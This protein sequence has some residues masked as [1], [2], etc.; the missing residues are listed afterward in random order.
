MRKDKAQAKRLRLSN[1]EDKDMPK[2]YCPHA[3]ALPTP[4]EED[5][6]ARRLVAAGTVEEFSKDLIPVLK[7]R[8]GAVE[9]ANAPDITPVEPAGKLV[10]DSKTVDAFPVP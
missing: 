4:T 1:P 9:P 3:F 10:D 5:P 2:L 8:F 7:A 6:E